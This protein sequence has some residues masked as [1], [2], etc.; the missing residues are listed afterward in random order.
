V[1]NLLIYTVYKW[2]IALLLIFPGCA[3][4][5]T[6]FSHLPKPSGLAKYKSPLDF[7][8]HHFTLK[9]VD[10][11]KNIPVVHA[12]TPRPYVS[13]VNFWSS[14]A[15]VICF[16]GWGRKIIFPLDMIYKARAKY[17]LIHEYVHHLDDMD[18]DNLYEFI[19]HREFAN[20]FQ[21][22]Q[23]DPLYK[24]NAKDILESAD[25]W[26]TN[27]FGIGKWSEAIAYTAEWLVKKDGPKYMWQVFREMLKKPLH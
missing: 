24:D 19:D 25:R 26:L 9:A 8:N 18:R 13:G 16:H 10:A 15:A 14:A 22:L 1:Y 27:V 17:T 5:I 7:L 21:R 3:T 11:L 23:K 6:D 20:A 2:I 12:P 4:P